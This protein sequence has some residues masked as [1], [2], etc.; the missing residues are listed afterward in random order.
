[1]SALD[2]ILDAPANQGRYWLVIK[3]DDGLV[4]TVSLMLDGSEPMVLAANKFA[5][6]CAVS[7]QEMAQKGNYWP[8]NYHV[9]GKPR[10]EFE[11]A[12]QTYL[13]KVHEVG[14]DNQDQAKPE[15]DR[16]VALRPSLDS[17]YWRGLPPEAGPQ[18]PLLA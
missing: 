14:W 13:K 18:P 2:A 10:T 12:T 1:M 11:L 7:R 4:G 15:F 3:D 16:M 9:D 5:D 6:A 8:C 17:P